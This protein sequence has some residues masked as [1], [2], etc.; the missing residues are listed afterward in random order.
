MK[1]PFHL[2]NEDDISRWGPMKD[3][4]SWALF[5]VAYAA[6]GLVLIIAWQKTASIT[7]LLFGISFLLGGI[8]NASHASMSAKGMD[9]FFARKKLQFAIITRAFLAVVFAGYFLITVLPRSYLE[10]VDILQIFAVAS[11]PLVIA[12]TI[13]HFVARVRYRT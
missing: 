6:V 8:V 4:K 13:E 11:L 12:G 7:A 10:S 5:A 1:L 9:K 3:R 2:P